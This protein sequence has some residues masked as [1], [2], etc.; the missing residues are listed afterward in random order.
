MEIECVEIR[1]MK[2]HLLFL[3]LSMGQL[4]YNNM[5]SLQTSTRDQTTYA[6][7]ASNVSHVLEPDSSSEH[8]I[9]MYNS[10]NI[11]TNSQIAL[12]GA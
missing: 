6:Q 3:L 4:I 11:R 1:R 10:H 2:L 12:N 9:C 5:R 8:F 7:Y